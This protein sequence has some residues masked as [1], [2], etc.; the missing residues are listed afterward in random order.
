M[1]K[2]FYFSIWKFK[3]KNDCF[4][5]KSLLGKGKA[6]HGCEIIEMLEILTTQACGQSQGA[7]WKPAWSHAPAL[8]HKN[9]DF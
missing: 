3:K 2:N 9:E 7:A 6:R 1:R 5:S 8:T 4:H